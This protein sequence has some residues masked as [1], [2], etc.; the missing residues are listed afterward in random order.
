MKNLAKQLFISAVSALSLY[1]IVNICCT[2]R[3]PDHA[4]PTRDGQLGTDVGWGWNRWQRFAVCFNLSEVF[5]T[6]ITYRKLK[7]KRADVSN[8]MYLDSVNIDTSNIYIC[9]FV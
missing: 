8:T 1:L 7:H 2:V 3:V 6:N 9:L 5:K 4:E